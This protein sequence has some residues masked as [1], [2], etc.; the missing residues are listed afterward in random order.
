MSRIFY[1]QKTQPILPD[2][3]TPETVMESKWHQPWS[4]PKRFPKGLAPYLQ[5]AFTGDPSPFPTSRNMGWYGWL[6]EPVRQKPGLL[7]ALQQFDALQ[8]PVVP[9]VASFIPWYAPFADPVR[10]KPGLLAANQAFFFYGPEFPEDLDVDWYHPFSEPKRFKPGLRAD[11][12]QFFAYHPRILPNPDVTATMAATETNADVF[13]GAI[14][15]YNGGGTTPGQGAKVSIVEIGPDN[16]P[17]SIE[18]S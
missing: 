8:A 14:N 7:A 15:V 1:Q 5:Q 6:S 10:L 9:Q 11:L 13:L 18:E 12:Q 16:D 17:V 2:N 3:L 4:E